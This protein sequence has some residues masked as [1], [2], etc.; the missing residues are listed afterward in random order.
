[1]EAQRADC[2]AD[3][4]EAVGDPRSGSQPGCS[5]KLPAELFADA[6]ELRLTALCGQLVEQTPDEQPQMARWKLERLRLGR[7][8]V[9]LGRTTGTGPGSACPAREARLKQPHTEEPFEP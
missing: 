1:M 8:R 9:Q 4:L 6:A 3:T 2:R 5:R 7:G